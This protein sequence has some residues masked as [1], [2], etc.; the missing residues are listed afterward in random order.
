M[1]TIEVLKCL[2]DLTRARIVHLLA[3][4]GPELCVCDIV[5][6]LD[7]PQS[8]VSRQLMVLRYLGLVQD[9][10]DGVWMHYSVAP[11]DGQAHKLVL[12]LVRKGLADEPVFA[13]DLARYDELND[14]GEV[15]RCASKE[16]NGSVR[17][18]EAGTTTSGRRNGGRGR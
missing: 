11:P 3:C 1:R 12:D 6:T 14:R 13:A 17:K 15:H 4:R 2:S 9:R 10:R 16:R 5:A 18:S 7:L 8:T